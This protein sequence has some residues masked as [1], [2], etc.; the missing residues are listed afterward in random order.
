MP[1]YPSNAEVVL[2]PDKCL[3]ALKLRAHTGIHG[4]SLFSRQVVSD[5]ATPWTAALLTSLTFSVSWSLL[6]LLSIELV[7]PVAP[8]PPAF[9]LSQHQS[10][11]QRVNSLHQVAKIL[12]R[13]LQQ[14]SS[15][16]NIW[17]R[18]PLGLTSLIQP[19]QHFTWCTLH[20]S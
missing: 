8:S 7:M 11:F 6:R 12:E 16:M 19:A 15:Q 10:L 2:T 13:Q 5:S 1:F 3:L 9:S 14:Q 4:S 20:V 17:G 18:F